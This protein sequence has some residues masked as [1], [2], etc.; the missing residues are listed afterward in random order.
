LPQIT[1]PPVR[2]PDVRLREQ[3]I[4]VATAAGLKV[5]NV[6]ADPSGARGW[7]EPRPARSRS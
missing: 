6:E 1:M 3:I 4:M 2:A 5:V 7:Y